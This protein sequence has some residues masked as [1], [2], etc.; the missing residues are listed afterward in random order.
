M[1]THSRDEVSGVRCRVSDYSGQ[2]TEVRCDRM[3]L[4]DY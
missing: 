4:D 2:M 1:V 3:K